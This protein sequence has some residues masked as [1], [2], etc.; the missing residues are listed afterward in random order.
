MSDSW[1]MVSHSPVL[2]AVWRD[3]QM[4]LEVCPHATTMTVGA[5]HFH[6]LLVGTHAYN[7]AVVFAPG[8]LLSSWVSTRPSEVEEQSQRVILKLSLNDWHAVAA[9][10]RSIRLVQATANVEQDNVIIDA[11]DVATT[12]VGD[13][14]LNQT[15]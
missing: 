11:T 2:E 8:K 6:V 3:I 1:A 9:T 13:A 10:C 15:L 12:V 7:G 4:S 14:V 5:Q